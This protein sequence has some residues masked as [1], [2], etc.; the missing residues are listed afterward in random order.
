MQTLSNLLE[1]CNTCETLRTFCQSI[2]SNNLP[3]LLP[4]V[5]RVTDHVISSGKDNSTERKGK[6]RKRIQ[7]DL[8][9]SEASNDGCENTINTETNIEPVEIK[10]EKTASE[11]AENMCSVKALSAFS[12][13]YDTVG[14]LDIVQ[15]RE[16]QKIVNSMR[17]T[18]GRRTYGSIQPGLND[19]LP[20]F[21]V[22]SD[23]DFQVSRRYSSE[24]EVRTMC[25]LYEE[26]DRVQEEVEKL[27]SNNPAYSEEYVLPVL[28][29]NEKFSVVDRSQPWYVNAV[30]F[31]NCLKIMILR[32]SLPLRIESTIKFH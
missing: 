32:E 7:T 4:L 15:T 25:R 29:G 17:T 13:F 20:K 22:N 26:I 5:T 30:L 8:Y 21:D 2:M 1:S 19:S 3:L 16:S 24:V 23:I 14:M 31:V 11:K 28:R 27:C 6:K 9:D 12:R 18:C 10:T